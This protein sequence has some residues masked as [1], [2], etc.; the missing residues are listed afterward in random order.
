M[1]KLITYIL[2][3]LSTFT[4]S[5]GKS[6]KI[7][8]SIDSIKHILENETLSSKSKVKN[9]RVLINLY[10][11]NNDLDK[12]IN[13]NKKLSLLAIKEKDTFS[14]ALS[15]KGYAII[16]TLKGEPKKS[17]DDFKTAIKILNSLKQHLQKRE[18]LN[19]TYALL[20]ETY[21]EINNY[22]E[23][24]S[25]ILKSLN[26]LPK[27]NDSLAKYSQIDAYN[28]LGF[29]NSEIENNSEALT[30]LKKA[31]VLEN[32]LNDEL[33]KINTYN[34]I[35]IIYSKQ[36][37][38]HKA[39][40]YYQLALDI[41]NKNGLQQNSAAL[42]NNIG[43]SYYG[44]N[45]YD[46]ARDM[47]FKAIE[48]G[49]DQQQ[50]ILADS[51]LYIGKSYIAENKID[52]GL[53]NINKSI[54]FAKNNFKSIEIENLL[55]KAAVEKKLQ[56]T[57]K[58]IIYLNKSLDLLDKT[59]TIEIKKRVY[60]KLADIHKTINPEKAALYNSMYQ[61]VKDSIIKM[62]Q[63]NK[64]EVLK[65]EFNYIKIKTDLKD[66]EADLLLAQEKE[67]AVKKENIFIFTIAILLIMFLAITILRQNKLNKTRKNMWAVKND[68]LALKQEN[69]EKEIQFKNKQITDFAIHIAE[70]NDLLE[71][72]K[73]KIKKIPVLNKTIAS[74]INDVILFINDDISQNKEKIQ[75]YTEINETTSSFNHKLTNLYPDLTNKEKRI[76][77]LV[78][79]NN[80]SKQISLQLNI[81]PASVDNYR[82]S[83]RKKMNVP[84]GLPIA[85]FI[86]SI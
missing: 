51:Y 63:Y 82:S 81:T 6:K 31:L 2:L 50:G 24:S 11:Y 13:I 49:K 10:I 67:I 25:Y 80:T 43:I 73:Q 8:K 19:I 40:E 1:K 62:Q 84:K 21:S 61:K 39:L 78:R 7:K 28:L 27:D 37:N 57:S 47:L 86:K 45:D 55:V 69:T 56:N 34:A 3:G 72:L 38:E 66:K 16:N 41:N 26:Y 76:I 54:E 65:A 71:N 60:E 59:E 15:H 29:I 46:K 18:Q 44:L 48:I 52:L 33:G 12:A 79:L 30:N 22:G 83:L 4:Y 58:A 5:Q 68:L 53:V 64:T 75:L 14:I 36:K 35:G 74:Q 9:M 70:K 77:T 17:I 23:A 42:Y 32:E 20:A 85:K